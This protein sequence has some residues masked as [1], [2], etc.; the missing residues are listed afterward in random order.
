LL[1]SE[2]TKTS[3]NHDGQDWRQRFIEQRVKTHRYLVF[4]A[5][6]HGVDPHPKCFVLEGLGHLLIA[7]EPLINKA[8]KKIDEFFWTP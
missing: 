6:H 2:S 1:L 4:S 8:T 3:A 5:H 7:V